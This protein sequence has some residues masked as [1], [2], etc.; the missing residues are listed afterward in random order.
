MTTYL[1][2]DVNYD[3]WQAFKTRAQSEGHPLRW[4]ILTLISYYINHG[5]PGGRN[6]ETQHRV[7]R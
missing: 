6:D 4:V 2:R 1:L 5:L 7:D 3:L